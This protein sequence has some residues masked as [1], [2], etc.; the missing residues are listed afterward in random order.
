MVAEGSYHFSKK[1]EGKKNRKKRKKKEKA[2]LSQ[3]TEWS[4][5]RFCEEKYSFGRSAAETKRKIFSKQT[6]RA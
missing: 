3:P 1:E 4:M 6:R 5:S 2:L